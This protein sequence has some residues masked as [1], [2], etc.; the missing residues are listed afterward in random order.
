MERYKALFPKSDDWT[1]KQLNRAKMILTDEERR[2]DYIKLLDRTNSDD[3]LKAGV[4]GVVEVRDA[5]QAAEKMSFKVK[6]DKKTKAIAC[7][8]FSSLQKAIAEAFKINIST[9]EIFVVDD[10]GDELIIESQ[11]ELQESLAQLG[12]MKKYVA[13]VRPLY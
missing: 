11:Q 9:H 12:D 3:G 8:D 1:R 5:D 6:M 2:K 7:F 10:D 13:H 4:G